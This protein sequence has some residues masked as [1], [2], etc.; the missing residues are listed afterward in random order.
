MTAE[1]TGRAIGGIARA[2]ALSKE[3]RH[4]IARR[5][6]LVR[7][8]GPIKEATHGSA[9]HPLRIGAIEIPATSSR[10]VRAFCRNAGYRGVSGCH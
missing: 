7:W 5:A 6:A 9:D 3:K 4:D 1:P 8:A 10:M 2:K